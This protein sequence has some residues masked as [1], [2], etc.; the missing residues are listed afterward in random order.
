MDTDHVSV[1]RTDIAGLRNDI[2]AIRQEIGVLEAKADSLEVW[3]MH[4]LTQEDQTMAKMFAKI[5][6][7]VA[8][9]SDMRADVSR[10]RGE[11]DAERRV[12]MMIISLLSA[13]CGGLLGSLAHG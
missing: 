9:M 2:S 5:D 3:R 8:A 4:Y 12:S 10:M 13:V 6:E 1:L 11:R 7:L